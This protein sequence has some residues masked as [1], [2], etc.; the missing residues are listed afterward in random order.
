MTLSGNRSPSWPSSHVS[1][2]WVSPE[3]VII[4]QKWRVSLEWTGANS[5][6]APRVTPYLIVLLLH[7]CQQELR[8][9][10]ALLKQMLEPLE[11]HVMRVPLPRL[12]GLMGKVGS[13]YIN[14]SGLE[15][16]QNISDVETFQLWLVVTWTP[17]SWPVSYRHTSIRFLLPNI[18]TSHT[19]TN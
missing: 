15:S 11:P 16:I 9:D 3:T 2:S 1:P 5:L 8:I 6:Y 13:N 7:F 19:K 12:P 14:M 18:C 4:E 17:W 10:V